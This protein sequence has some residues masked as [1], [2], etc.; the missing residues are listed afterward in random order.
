M[1]STNSTLLASS[2]AVL[3]AALF[4]VGC[5]G[6]DPEPVTF[7]PNGCRNAKK[8]APKD[9][10]IA[11]STETLDPDARSIVN[12][13]TNCGDFQVLLDAKNNPRTSSSMAHLVQEGF[14]DGTWFHRIVTGFVI[15]GG[16]PAGDGSGGTGW[17][18][19]EP[20]TG[21]YRVGT[22]AM[23]KSA[24]DPTGTS[25]SQFYIVIGKDG[26]DLPPDYAIAGRLAGGLD[27]VEKIA[28]YAPGENEQTDVPVGV[29]VIEKATLI[30]DG[31]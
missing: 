21:D 14:Y 22:V 13:R 20:P 7:D 1:R 26:T 23:A 25:S 17:D 12:F 3:V 15:Q 6:D 18:I 2:A 8:P 16:D 28:Q 10:D 4:L 5:G 27:V 24:N 30:V 31:E 9:V 11:R 19:V 29:A